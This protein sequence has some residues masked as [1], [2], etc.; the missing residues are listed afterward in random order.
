M[1]FHFTALTGGQDGALDGVD[2]TPLRDMDRAFCIVGG[3]FSVY[4]LDADSGLTESSPSII[5]PDTNAGQ[6]RWILCT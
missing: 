4:Y 2:G 6:K 1:L 5:S 3:A